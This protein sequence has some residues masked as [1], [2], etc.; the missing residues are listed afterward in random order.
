[1]VALIAV[2]YFYTQSV[3]TSWKLIHFSQET[4]KK[5]IIGKQCRPR[6]DAAEHSIDQGLH[7]LHYIQEFLKKKHTSN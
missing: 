3:V 2:S 6:S 1:M 4:Q 7:C 5:R